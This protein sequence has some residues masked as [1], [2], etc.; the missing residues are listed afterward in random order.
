MIESEIDRV[1]IYGWQGSLIQVFKMI[2]LLTND[3][4][5]NLFLITGY[6]SLKKTP[7]RALSLKHVWSNKN[8]EENSK[9]EEPLQEVIQFTV[10]AF[11]ALALI[12]IW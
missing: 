12:R 6:F 8:Q 10:L 3:F 2:N 7:F 5:N 11:K 9:H 1:V 4:I